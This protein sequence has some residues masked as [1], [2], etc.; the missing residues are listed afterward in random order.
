MKQILTIIYI[1]SVIAVA[2]TASSPAKEITFGE[3]KAEKLSEA[4]KLLNTALVL[5]QEKK[6]EQAD[7]MIKKALP[8]FNQQLGEN[9]NFSAACFNQFGILSSLRNRVVEASWYMEKSK[10]IYVK[11]RGKDHIDNAQAW[12]NMGYAYRRR[13][14]VKIN[15]ALDAYNEALR[16]LKLHPGENNIRIAQVYAD[17]SYTYLR[18]KKPEKAREP[19]L[20]ALAICEKLQDP[21]TQAAAA[22][23]FVCASYFYHTGKLDCAAELIEK[24]INIREKIYGPKD[25]LLQIYKR[26]LQ[27]IKTRMTK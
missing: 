5:R 15:R 19:C 26:D 4:K 7:I 27:R 16:I 3:A 25:S 10:D 9:N 14:R 23:Y 6:Y 1:F 22:V 12:S 8:V 17:I 2:N 11:I 20:K 24:A 18:L 13:R 21:P